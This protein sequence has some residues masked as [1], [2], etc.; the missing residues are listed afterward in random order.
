MLIYLDTNVYCRPFDNQSDDVISQETEAFS[1][2]CDKIKSGEITLIS[3][4][5]L[6]Y[7]ISLIPDI[8]IRQKVLESQNIATVYVEINQQ[9]E[10]LFKTFT[11]VVNLKPRDALHLASSLIPPAEAFITCDKGIINK[12]DKIQTIEGC[13]NILIINPVEFLEVIK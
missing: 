8:E 10:K 1:I 4:A 6:K 12:K 2:I 3:S 9:L 13:Q 11:D 5:I 7:E